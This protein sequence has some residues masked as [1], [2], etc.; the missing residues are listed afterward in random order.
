[1]ADF[2]VNTAQKELKTYSNCQNIPLLE[3]SPFSSSTKT[4]TKIF[5]DEAIIIFVDELKI[6]PIIQTISSM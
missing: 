4:M 5:V 6:V 3:E 1:M 2:F